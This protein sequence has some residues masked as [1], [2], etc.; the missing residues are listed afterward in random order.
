M[1]S[2]TY[3]DQRRAPLLGLFLL[4]LTFSL[5]CVLL[6]L[7]HLPW[8]GGE[9]GDVV[10]GRHLGAIEVEKVLYTQLRLLSEMRG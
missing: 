2:E 5:K 6:T 10:R 3:G 8:V 7:A 1:A 9:L 4:C